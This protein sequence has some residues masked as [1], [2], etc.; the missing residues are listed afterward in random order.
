MLVLNE[1][2]K[3]IGDI[4]FA[5][6]TTVIKNIQRSIER[7][8]LRWTLNFYSHW[9][10]LY[11]ISEMIDTLNIG[12]ESLT[13]ASSSTSFT[14]TF[15]T[16]Y[17]RHHV[18][19]FSTSKIDWLQKKKCTKAIF[20]CNC[21]IHVRWNSIWTQ[22]YGDRSRNVGRTNL[23]KD[24]ATFS[25]EIAYS[26]HNGDFIDSSDIAKSLTT[27]DG[28]FNLCVPLSL[29]FGFCEDCKRV[30]IN[31]RHILDTSTQQ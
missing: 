6:E 14:R 10:L 8:S 21:G 25:N 13:I 16:I 18:K 1:Q 27:D 20:G 4:I 15:R 30:L 29:L 17:T 23:M 31:A 7:N 2:A 26:L 22:W 3:Q 11:E 24:Y 5:R 28:Y 19:A 9:A 12:G